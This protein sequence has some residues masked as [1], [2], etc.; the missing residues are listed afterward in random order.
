V[1]WFGNAILAGIYLQRFR[2]F[3]FLLAVQQFLTRLALEGGHAIHS[4]FVEFSVC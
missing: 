3:G 4:T 1:F 2:V